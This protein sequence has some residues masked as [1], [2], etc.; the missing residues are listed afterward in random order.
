MALTVKDF[1]KVLKISDSALLERMQNAGLQHK[2]SSDEI[3]PADK[4]AL[5]KSLKN[6]KSQT[7]SVSSDSGIKVVSKGNKVESDTPK[8]YSDNIEAKRAAAS[9]QL[10]EQQKKRED[11]IKEATRLKKE[12]REQRLASKKEVVIQPKVN[13][14]DQLSRASKEYNKN[15]QEELLVLMQSINL[16]HLQK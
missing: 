16:K 14:K 8:S 13:I 15:N 5:L 2:S 1:A 7:S 11:Q 12:E 3:T 10:K 9:E 4:S 6:R